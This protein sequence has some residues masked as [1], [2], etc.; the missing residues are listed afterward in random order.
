[1]IVHISLRCKAIC[2]MFKYIQYYI[3]L[4]NTKPHGSAITETLETGTM[5][6]GFGDNWRAKAFG[7]QTHLRYVFING[8]F[9]IVIPR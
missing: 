7:V 4:T 6:F 2:F 1:M 9:G 8:L 3:S 5:V